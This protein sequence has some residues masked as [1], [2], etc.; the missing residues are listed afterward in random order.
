VTVR[1]LIGSRRERQAG[2][3]PLGSRSIAAMVP[4]VAERDVYLCGP[5]SMMEAVAATVVSLG[6]PAGHVHRE[7][8]DD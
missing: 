1:Y 2:G 5:N 6:V 3:D 4:D 8:F 7:R